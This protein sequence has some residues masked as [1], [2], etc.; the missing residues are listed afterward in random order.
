MRPPFLQRV[1]YSMVERGTE[2]MSSRPGE[3]DTKC[4]E[5]TKPDDEATYKQ[6]HLKVQELHAGLQIDVQI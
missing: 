2:N 3:V 1:H 5:T 6:T 4:I